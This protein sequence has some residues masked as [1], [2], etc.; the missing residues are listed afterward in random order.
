LDE[1]KTIILKLVFAIA[2]FLLVLFGIVFYN[3]YEKENAIKNFTAV[4]ASVTSSRITKSSRRTQKTVLTLK[5]IYRGQ[6]IEKEIEGSTL[7]NL[8]HNYYQNRQKVKRNG[9]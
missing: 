9:L 8:G 2:V 7:S 5:Y 1:I 4:E 6:E 3:R